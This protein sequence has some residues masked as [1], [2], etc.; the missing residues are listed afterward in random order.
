M[1]FALC[2]VLAALGIW[3][4]WLLARKHRHRL[5]ALPKQDRRLVELMQMGETAMKNGDAVAQK[6]IIKSIGELGTG[7][8]V[9]FIADWLSTTSLSISWP[10]LLKGI[11]EVAKHAEPQWK[12]GVFRILEKGLADPSTPNLFCSWPF[13]SRPAAMM[14]V[15]PDRALKAF[16]DRK[17]LELGSPG[18]S[19]TVTA[20]NESPFVVPADIAAHWLPAAI[21]DLSDHVILEQ[22]LL[23]LRAHAEHDLSEAKRRLWELI[24]SG[25]HYAA[26]AA[27][28]LLKAEALPDP[29]WTLDSRVQEIGLDKV[30]PAERIVWTVANWFTFPIATSGFDRFVVGYEAD[31]LHETIV[32]LKEIGAPVTARCLQEWATI[33]GPE[34]PKFQYDREEMINERQ[35]K[36]G[37]HWNTI[38]ARTQNLENVTLLNLLYELRH[39]DQFERQKC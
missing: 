34:W 25:E 16:A 39:A 19:A 4:W 36:P 5:E 7:A 18:F 24:N 33:F 1:S 15:D 23:M 27:Q 20:I 21:P 35:L 29:V 10:D 9:P 31:H 28:L 6:E 37:E 8:S 13:V 2:T 3:L 22:Y 14:A 32:A 12:D 17:L 11:V 38:C 26:G 30:R